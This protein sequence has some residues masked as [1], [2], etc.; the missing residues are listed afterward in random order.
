MGPAWLYLLVAD[1]VEAAVPYA[2]VYRLLHCEDPDFQI[3]LSGA[4]DLA[5]CLGTEKDPS[6]PGVVVVLA[7]GSVLLVGDVLMQKPSEKV[8]YMA[9]RPELFAVPEP[10]CRGV[11]AGEGRWAFVLE[12]SAIA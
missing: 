2:S 7:S 1:G 6:L 11:L 5:S 4:V 3:N 10:W 8:S 12:E 9:L